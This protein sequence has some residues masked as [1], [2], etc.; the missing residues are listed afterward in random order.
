[1]IRGE[2]S[3]REQSAMTGFVEADARAL[4]EHFL[5]WQ[6]R[7]R[8]KAV[9]EDGGRP[10]AGMR[11]KVLLAGDEV[12]AEAMTVLIVEDDSAATTA[13][14]RHIVR[15]THDP[16]QRYDAAIKL[17]A[18]AYYQHPED[19]A[20]RLAA[21]FA[22]DSTVVARLSEAT[23]CVL[24]FQ[25]YGQS[26]RLPCAVAL[27]GERDPFWQATY[28]HNA[29]FNPAM[30]PSPMVLAFDPDWAAA[31]AFPPVEMPVRRAR[32]W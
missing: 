27:L 16:R 24:A 3:E 22:R 21:L 13:Q 1:M 15:K 17:L 32:G 25:Q 30:P 12:L 18:S 20:D 14:F 31:T 8:Q 10:T 9:R 6:C 7:L 2:H 28:W 4:R 29:M 5:G 19:F 26:Y 23:R 11:P